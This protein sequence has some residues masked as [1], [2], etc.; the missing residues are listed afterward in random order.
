MCLQH[1]VAVSG[2]EGGAESDAGSDDDTYCHRTISAAA[3]S[4]AA[5]CLVAG[6]ICTVRTARLELRAAC[7]VRGAY[8]AGRGPLETRMV[9]VA[10]GAALDGVCPTT[11]PEATESS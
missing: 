4:P 2:A 5:N 10:P 1:I 9:I 3:I 7:F 8:A 6:L 11:L